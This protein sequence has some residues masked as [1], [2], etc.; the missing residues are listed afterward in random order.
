MQP[1]VKAHEVPTAD[2]DSKDN[3]PGWD[4]PTQTFIRPHTFNLMFLI[5]GYMQAAKPLALF[6]APLGES[7]AQSSN[8]ASLKRAQTSPY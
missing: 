3:E 7:T 5:T 4:F 2:V 1:P 6:P 8:E